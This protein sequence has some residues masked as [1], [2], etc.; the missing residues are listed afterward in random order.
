MTLARCRPALGIGQDAAQLWVL[1]KTVPDKA[2]GNM[3]LSHGRR[4]RWCSALGFGHG[5]PERAG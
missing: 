2:L 5:A 1:G 4:A 3:P